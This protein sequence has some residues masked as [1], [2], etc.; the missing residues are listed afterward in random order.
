MVFSKDDLEV[1][2]AF[3]NEKGW[4]F[5][6]FESARLLSLGYLARTCL[7]RKA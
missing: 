1:L 6:R 7:G 5:T 4:T 3:F 2:V